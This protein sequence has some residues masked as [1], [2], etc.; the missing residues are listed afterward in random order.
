MVGEAYFTRLLDFSMFAKAVAPSS[1]R[2][3]ATRSSFDNDRANGRW[4]TASHIERTPSA[5]MLQ[6]PR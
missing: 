4:D 6:Y 2:K 1:F 3:F 5:L